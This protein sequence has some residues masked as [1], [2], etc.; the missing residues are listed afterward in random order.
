M[1][2]LR[3]LKS[4]GKV[5]KRF[6]GS[7]V[8]KLATT[9][10]QFIGIDYGIDALSM[11]FSST[12]QARLTKALEEEGV[13]DIDAIKLSDFPDILQSVDGTTKDIVQAELK[14][15]TFDATRIKALVDQLS[16]QLESHLSEQRDDFVGALTV[17]ICYFQNLLSKQGLKYFSSMSDVANVFT[18]GLLM[19]LAAS[20]P[21]V[22]VLTKAELEETKVALTESLDDLDSHKQRLFDMNAF[23]TLAAIT[24]TN[25]S[26]N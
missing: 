22:E 17:L 13:P 9:V 8:G 20:A 2:V 21:G 12:D 26:V 19:T 1:P 25:T 6:A 15:T 18:M 23:Y 16:V 14:Q 7:G 24:A 10:V 4:F 5:F 11:A 3:F